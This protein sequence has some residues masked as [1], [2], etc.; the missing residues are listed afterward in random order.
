M[1]DVCLNFILFLLIFKFVS[2][3]LFSSSSRFWSWSFSASSSVSPYPK[4]KM[5]SATTTMPFNPSTACIILYWYSSDAEQIPNGSRWN[6]YLPNGVLNVVRYVDSSSSW[7]C[8]NPLLASITEKILDFLSCGS[9]SS[10]VGRWKI[11]RFIASF[12]S[13]GSIQI[14][15]F[16]EL[17]FLTITMLDT[18]SVGSVTSFITP[19][20]SISFSCFF[21]W[22]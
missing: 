11:G 18:H 9:T 19:Y 16:S 13:V 5:S 14:L 22:S 3:H 4:T 2:L 8:Q 21:N 15:S 1:S 7:T 17:G 12:K 6:L 20:S 10:I